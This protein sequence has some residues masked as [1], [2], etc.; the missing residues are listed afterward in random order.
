MI[1]TSLKASTTLIFPS[2]AEINRQSP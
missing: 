2:E 1:P